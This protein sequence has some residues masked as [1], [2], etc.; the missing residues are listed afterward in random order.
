MG[1]GMVDVPVFVQIATP[2]EIFWLRPWESEYLGDAPRA[3]ILPK[4]Y[5]GCATA[6]R[7]LPFESA[8]GCTNQDR[9][10]TILSLTG[11]TAAND[12]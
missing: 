12:K 4:S 6:W 7:V 10:L 1:I 5:P 8:Y 3:P 9:T 2:L 11:I